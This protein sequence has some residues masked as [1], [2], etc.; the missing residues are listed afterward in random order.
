V[1]NILWMMG[2]NCCFY[3][4][5]PICGQNTCA[6]RQDCTFTRSIH[7]DCPGVCLFDGIC[8]GSRDS[9]YRAYW[10]TTLHTEFY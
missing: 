1:D 4:Y 5:A 7:Y 8:L 9:A 6:R 2:R 3:D 10:E